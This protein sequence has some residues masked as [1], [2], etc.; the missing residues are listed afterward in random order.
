MKRTLLSLLLAVLL[1]FS[2]CGAVS[3]PDI[4]GHPLED[5]VQ[6]AVEL[7]IIKGYTD[8]NFKPANT[9][10]RGEFITI[11]ARILGI[12]DKLGSL[13]EGKLANIAVFDGD[14]LDTRTHCVMTLIEGKIVHERA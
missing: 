3:F 10:T 1:L 13:D 2:V 5:A 8:G 11:V 7:G 9:I 14:P 4:G 6:R 12:D